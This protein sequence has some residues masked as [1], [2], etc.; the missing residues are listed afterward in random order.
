MLIEEEILG[1][2]APNYATDEE[3][4]SEMIKTPRIVFSP[5]SLLR[6]ARENTQFE[7]FAFVVSNSETNDSGGGEEER[8]GEL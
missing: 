5:G 1:G 2:D 4:D 7:R 8:P 3:F 6:K